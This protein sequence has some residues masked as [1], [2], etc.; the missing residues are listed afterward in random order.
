VLGGMIM[1]RAQFDVR[2]V[3][4]LDRFVKAI[5]QTTHRVDIGRAPVLAVIIVAADCYQGLR[6]GAGADSVS[7][8]PERSIVQSIFLVIVADAV[9]SIIFR[10]SD[11]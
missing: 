1:V 5:S 8:Q 7:L 3:Q 9:F 4:Y 2:F 11:L 10:V 6:I